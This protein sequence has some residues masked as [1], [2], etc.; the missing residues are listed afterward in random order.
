MK[1]FEAELEELRSTL[2]AMK[3]SLEA[4]T[5]SKVDLQNSIQSLKEE[6]AFR[7]KVYEEVREVFEEMK[8]EEC[9]GEK[10]VE[11]RVRRGECK[12]AY[13]CGDVERSFVATWFTASLGICR[14]SPDHRSSTL[15]MQI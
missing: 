14:S 4:E 5:L 2:E 12:Y 9:V 15:P 11:I 3:E 6:L 10:N 7:K 13:A 1:E 8:D